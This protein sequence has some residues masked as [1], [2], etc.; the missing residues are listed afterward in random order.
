MDEKRLK[1]LEELWLVSA[2]G[3]KTCQQTWE[4]L[5]NYTN[6]NI[7]LNFKFNIPDL[8][9]GTLDV[10]VALSDD[11][12]KLDMYVEGV[13]RK[14]GGYMG[15][16]ME[17]EKDK[18]KESLLVNGYSMAAYL[19]RFQW[20]LAKYS[21]NQAIP[22]IT[23]LITKQVTQMEADLKA[24]AASYNNLKGTLQNLEKKTMGSLVSRSLVDLVK[25]EDFV[26]GSDY[27]TTA[28]VVV[29]KHHQKDFLNSYECLCDMIIPRSSKVIATDEEYVLYGVSLF[30][31]VF[32]DFKR[33][34]REKRWVVRDFVYKEEEWL[35]GRSEI[36]RLASDKKKQF[37]PL[38]RW[39]RVNFGESFIALIHVKALRLYVESVLRYGLPV[40]FQPMLL[41]PLNNKKLRDVLNNLYHHLDTSGVAG[42]EMAEMSGL[43]AAS[44]EYYPY[45]FYKVPLNIAATTR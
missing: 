26:L 11:L 1:E 4:K 10:L 43:L 36:T 41:A 21:T 22:S 24:K 32:E 2:P 8:K 20:D 16:V 19:S 14:I 33:L 6:N 28:L 39:L 34:A 13:V 15:E 18:L 17:G 23:T 7:S 31:K 5:N 9:V 42:I 37:G 35:S 3:D 44:T 45:V 38:V 27:L 40:N 12:A 25:K 29:N 30:K